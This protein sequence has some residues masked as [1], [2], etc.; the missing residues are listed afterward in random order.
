MC[1]VSAMI[2]VHRKDDNKFYLEATGHS[3]QDCYD[4]L[5][6][7]YGV[8]AQVDD[9]YFVQE[10]FKTSDGIFVDRFKAYKIAAANNQLTATNDWGELQSWMVCYPT[11]QYN[12]NQV[13]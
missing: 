12:Y 2:L 4:Y 13:D 3:H 11:Q 1:I 8:F 5:R 10:G 7:A 6:N 9:N